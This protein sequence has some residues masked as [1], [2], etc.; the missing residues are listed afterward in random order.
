MKQPVLGLAL[1]LGSEA[2]WSDLLAVLIATDP[3][4]LIA[5]LDLRLDPSAVTVRREAAVDSANR[6]DIVLCADGMCVAVIEVKVLAG[7][8]ARQLARYRAALPGAK[9][10]A[11]IYPERLA[12]SLTEADAWRGLPWETVLRAYQRSSHSWAA[13]T[14]QAW[15]GHL[16]TSLP[17]VGPGT[18]WNDLRLGEDFV[19]ALR[20]RMSW[21]SAQVRTPAGVDH[22]LVESTA[23]VSWIA[24][25]YASSPVPGYM[26]MVEIE[27]NLPVRDYPKYVTADAPRPRGPSAK[28]CLRQ[29]GVTTSAGFDWDYLLRLWPVMRQARSDWVRNAARP[30]AA[31]DREGHARIVG[32]GAPPFLGIGFGEAQTKINCFC[33][34]GARIQF[35]ADITLADLAAEMAVLGNLTQDLAQIS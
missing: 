27:E 26:I 33:M 14:A 15:L 18:T 25:L 22:D 11:L 31:H 9:V 2:R 23:G 4:P 34:F 6:P 12:I 10:Y 30:K 13:A 8:G 20:A 19:I 3:A 24:R 16:S 5:V 21:L 28:V 17:R 35:P 7:L 29:E 32:A 1:P